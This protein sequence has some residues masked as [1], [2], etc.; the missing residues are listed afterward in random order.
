MTSTKCATCVLSISVYS[1]GWAHGICC[2]FGR[3]CCKSSC[4][5][6]GLQG[7]RARL[8]RNHS[9][10]MR[11]CFLASVLVVHQVVGAWQY[12]IYLGHACFAACIC[13]PCN[14]HV[15]H[16]QWPKR[17]LLIPICYIKGLSYLVCRD[18]CLRSHYGKYCRQQCAISSCV[19]SQQCFHPNLFCYWPICDMPK[20]KW[21]FPI[22]CI[23]STAFFSSLICSCMMSEC[24]CAALLLP[25]A[26]RPV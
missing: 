10:I 18:R 5:Y 23:S 21:V 2:R 17:W 7:R 13:L 26:S 22:L 1:N 8:S 4:S 16:E 14:S 9:G 19:L 6:K 25:F 24:L 12:I 11:L 3:W 15:P 20:E